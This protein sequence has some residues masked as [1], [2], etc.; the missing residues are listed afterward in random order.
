MVKY[1]YYISNKLGEIMDNIAKALDELI[2]IFKDD[3]SEIDEQISS[4]R[5]SEDNWTLKEII[6]HLIDSASNN[7]QRFVRLQLSEVMEFPDYHND[8]WLRI[9]NYQNM[10]FSD[11]LLLFYYYNKLIVNIILNLNEKCLVHR[12][13]TNWD[14]NSTFSTL[15]SLLNHYVSHMKSHL[16]HFRERL[17]E[18]EN[19][20]IQNI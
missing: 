20:D 1:K 7:H 19:C 10:C 17:E 6:G 2:R 9:Q 13:N 15:E 4:Y 8:E 12:W 5:I 18:L 16:T 11:L 3:F 14:E